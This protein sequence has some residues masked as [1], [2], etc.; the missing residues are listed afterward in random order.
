MRQSSAFYFHNSYII[1][2]FPPFILKLDLQKNNM[3]H[4]QTE[5]KERLTVNI[6]ES[7]LLLLKWLKI[8]FGDGYSF[9]VNGLITKYRNEV[10]EG[11]TALELEQIEA[12]KVVSDGGLIDKKKVGSLRTTV[13]L[14]K[15]DETL[16]DKA[17]REA[18][19]DLINLYE[20]D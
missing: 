1:C 10:T 15:V 9:I 8:N 16:K 7:N 3:A 18:L 20:N 14:G 19:K 12:L 4:S 13:M 5:K 11:M 6:D 17:K 2:P